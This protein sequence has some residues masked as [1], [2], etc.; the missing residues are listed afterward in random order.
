[1]I[2]RLRGTPTGA[3]AKGEEPSDGE[4]PEGGG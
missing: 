2:V 1:M 4:E 3:E